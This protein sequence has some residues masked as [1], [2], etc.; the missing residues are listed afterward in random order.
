M[1]PGKVRETEEGWY[2]IEESPSDDDAVVN[3]QPEHDCHGGVAHSL[4]ETNQGSKRI[5]GK[6]WTRISN[7]LQSFHLSENKIY[8]K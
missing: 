2:E 3:I 8:K 7:S 5:V 1:S 6:V 4:S